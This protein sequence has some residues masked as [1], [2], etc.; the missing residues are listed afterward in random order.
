MN[1]TIDA[2]DKDQDFESALNSIEK[3][4]KEIEDGSLPLNQIV[5]KFK[6]AV[7]QIN[8]CRAMLNQVDQRVQVLEQ[9]LKKTE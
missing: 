3:L 2:E 9:E 1:K 5:D 6:V 7:E 8:H 4:V